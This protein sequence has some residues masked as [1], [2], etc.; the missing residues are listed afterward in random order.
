MRR[1][2]GAYNKKSVVQYIA[3]R[4]K[5]VMPLKQRAPISIRFAESEENLIRHAAKSEGVTLTKFIKSNFWKAFHEKN[6]AS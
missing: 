1:S 4:L 2:P 6:Q 5:T 3:Y